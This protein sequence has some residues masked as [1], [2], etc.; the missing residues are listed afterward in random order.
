MHLHSKPVKKA[1]IRIALGV[2]VGLILLVLGLFLQTLAPRAHA[3]RE[4][5]RLITVHDRGVSTTFMTS[6]DTIGEALSV[7]G[8]ALDERDA[9]EPERNEKLVAADYQVNVYRARPVTVID[10]QLRKKVFTPYQ[11]A[12]RIIQDVDVSL[13]PEDEVQITR[14]DDVL[15]GG[16][17]LQLEVIRAVPFTFTLFGDTSTARTQA[18][19]VG[20]ML[21]EKGIEL[22][23]NDRTSLP[24]D[25]PIRAD[26][27]VR[28]WREGKQTVTVEEAVDFEV[29]QIRDAD[30]P[31]GQRE[32]KV[33]GEK[34]TRSVTYEVVI[35]GGEEVSRKEITS[36]AK[37]KPKKQVEIIGIKPKHMP[38][39][40]GGTKTE[41]LAASSIPESSWGYA[42]F[43]VARESGWNPNARNVS[44]GA[45][46]L[47]QALPC[48]KVPGNP[49]DPVNSLNWMNGYV[50][51]RYYSGSPYAKGLCGNISDNWQCAYAH[52]Q[53]YKWY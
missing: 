9:V 42:D 20:A 35:K 19:T 14:S 27:K 24:L 8:V 48:E 17:G 50:K 28:V 26:M 37:K 31:A 52:W 46:G 36:V 49:Y 12:E 33:K 13:Y 23:E 6:E 25:T 30:K 29:E 34:G 47:A 21:E 44:S 3:Q 43:M 15:N 16:G 38:Y 22:G 11:S 39:T 1:S 51:G 2:A 41:W 32:V 5:E 18:D 10:G 45:C 53:Q 7:A 4:G 40:G